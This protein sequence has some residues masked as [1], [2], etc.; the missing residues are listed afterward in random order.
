MDKIRKFWPVAA[1]GFTV[2]NA[3]GAI[4][5]VVMGEWNHA[6]VHGGLL[7]G[8]FAAWQVFPRKESVQPAQGEVDETR[9]DSLQES[10]DSIA[11]NVERMGE[12]QR[13]HEKLLKKRAE[14]PLNRSS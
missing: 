4:Y 1:I 10:V 13:F 9:L 6:M 14:N 12:A 11:L 7:V 3:A 2:I 8:G 5:A